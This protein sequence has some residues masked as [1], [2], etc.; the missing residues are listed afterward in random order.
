M[1]E[2]PTSK[3]E[4]AKPK[5]TVVCEKCGMEYTPGS[6]HVM[7]CRGNVKDGDQCVECGNDDKDL[8]SECNECGDPVCDCCKED[9]THAC[10]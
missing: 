10:F 5:Q 6:P 2:K 1:S 9:G 8:L 7:F 4:D 3:P